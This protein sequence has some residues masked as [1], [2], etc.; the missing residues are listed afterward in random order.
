MKIVR[1]LA[2]IALWI[3]LCVLI[4]GFPKAAGFVLGLG[5]IVRLLHAMVTGKQKNEGMH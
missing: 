1:C 2:D 3:A 4:A 5:F